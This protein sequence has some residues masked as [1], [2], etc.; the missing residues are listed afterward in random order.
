MNFLIQGENNFPEFDFG[1]ELIKSIEF[2]E[3]ELKEKRDLETLTIK[4]LKWFS[5]QLHQY[6]EYRKWCPIG[7]IEFVH[8]YFEIFNIPIP[9]PINIPEKLWLYSGLRPRN[10]Y[11]N[12]QL[13]RDNR[14]CFIKN[15]DKIKHLDNGPAKKTSSEKTNWQIT[16]YLS[17]GFLSEWRCFVFNGRLLD[18]KIYSGDWNVPPNEDYIKEA[19]KLWRDAPCCYTLD[20]GVS[21]PPNTMYNTCIIEAHNFYSCG[22]YGFSNRLKLPQMF[23]QW[24]SEWLRK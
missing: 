12:E 22:L 11:S 13:A 20:V 18:C 2:Q 6:G 7:S 4:N 1:W 19:I 21:S 15:K 14:F 17:E 10:A 24:Y 9:K 23:G 16:D 8:K 5:D 3:K